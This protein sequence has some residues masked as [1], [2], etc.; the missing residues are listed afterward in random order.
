MRF[1]VDPE[2]VV[3]IAEVEFG[4]SLLNKGMLES[5]LAS[6]FHTSDETD[7]FPLLH[8]KAAVLFRSMIK[9]HPFVDGNKRIGTLVLLRFLADNGMRIR[10]DEEITLRLLA[11]LVASDIPFGT[12]DDE[13]E[14][15]KQWFHKH[16]IRRPG[17]LPRL[18]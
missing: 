18:P 5:A 8:E 7:L 4:V 17:R 3:R 6:P 11:L 15:F 14:Y 9:N 1:A 12:E 16:L 2:E 13:M 10:K